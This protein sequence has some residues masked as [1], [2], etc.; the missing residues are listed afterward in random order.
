MI[1]GEEVV[2]PRPCIAAGGEQWDVLRSS[3]D[4]VIRFLLVLEAG[5]ILGCN[6]V[7]PSTKHPV[8]PVDW[9]DRPV[10]RTR[11]LCVAVASLPSIP[12]ILTALSGWLPP[13]LMGAAGRYWRSWGL[14]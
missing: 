5:A 12:P 10:R 4:D 8:P 1:L 11:E 14:R 7:G 9:W 3:P 6:G 13:E 2:G